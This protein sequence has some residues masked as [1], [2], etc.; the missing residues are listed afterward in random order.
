VIRSLLIDLDGTLLDNDMSRFIPAYLERLGSFMSDLVEPGKFTTVLM[1]GTQ[2]M[3]ANLDPTLPLQRVFADSF[4]PVLGIPE[5]VLLPRFEQFYA[6]EFPKLSPLTG[7]KAGADDLVRQA[8]RRGLEVV[9]ATNPMFPQTAVLQRLDWA[10]VPWQDT[11]ITFATSYETFHFC[12]PN[13]EY[14]VEVLGRLGRTASESA[15]VGDDPDNDLAPAQSLGIAPFNVGKQQRAPFPGGELED[16][17]PWSETVETGK[18]VRASTSPLLILAR[19][20]GNLAALLG[21][22][23]SLDEDRWARRPGPGEWS[24]GDILCHLRDAEIEVNI[25]RI[26]AILSTTDPFLSAADT[27]RWAV[28]RGYRT[29]SGPHAL[30]AFCHARVEMIVSLSDLAEASWRRTARHALLGDTDLAEI[31]TVMTDHDVIHLAQIRRIAG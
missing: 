9:I 25:P 28:E 23:A 17:L 7:R 12:K 13:P 15:M 26:K 4:Y 3:L 27:D 19:L 16:V 24:I 2:R 22:T 14:F 20:R 21:L 1:K 5:P 6:E 10:G 29:Q 31:V 18:A 8:A 11:T 30:R